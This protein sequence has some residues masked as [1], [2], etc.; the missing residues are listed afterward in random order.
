MA[1]YVYQYLRGIRYQNPSR[2][3]KMMN[4]QIFNFWHHSSSEGDWNGTLIPS[5]GLFE[6]CK[7]TTNLPAASAALAASGG[8]RWGQDLL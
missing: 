1:K 3:L 2:I 5:G 7:V 4:N 8:L 6:A